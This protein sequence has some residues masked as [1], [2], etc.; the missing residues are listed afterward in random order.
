[1]LIWIRSKV[2][3]GLNSIVSRLRTN[4]VKMITGNHMHGGE[5]DGTA[6]AKIEMQGTLRA[7]LMS[8]V[9]RVWAVSPMQLSF[10]RQLIRRMHDEG[11]QIDVPRLDL[12]EN[13]FGVAIITARAPAKRVSIRL[14][15]TAMISTLYAA[16]T[17]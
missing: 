8:C 3:T 6:D 16:A 10:S 2:A 7:L 15:P 4:R 11:W 5:Y 12:D 14:L 1:M 17:G 9:C 13:G